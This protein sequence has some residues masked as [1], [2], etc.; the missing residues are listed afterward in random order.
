MRVEHHFH[1]HQLGQRGR[2]DQLVGVLGKQDR[3]G[4]GVDHE[5]LLGLGLEKLRVR[6][7]RAQERELQNNQGR[8]RRE[9]RETIEC[10]VL[11]CPATSRPQMY[12]SWSD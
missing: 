5:G 9:R 10:T 4:F 11:T 1:G 6:L 7:S 12:Q 8:N 2:R 3:A